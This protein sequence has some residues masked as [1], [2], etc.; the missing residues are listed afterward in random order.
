MRKLCRI[1]DLL[2]K[3]S[4]GEMCDIFSETDEISLSII[5]QEFADV[6]ISNDDGRSHYVCI[7]CMQQI[8]TGHRIWKKIRDIE[9]RPYP[10]HDA[11]SEHGKESVD[12][13][14]AI[15][16]DIKLEQIIV[17]ENGCEN[18][19]GY[20]YEFLEDE[21]MDDNVDSEILK[22]SN[23][24]E[25]DLEDATDNF[26]VETSET[27]S[28]QRTVRDTHFEMPKAEV[29]V[30]VI[31]LLDHSVVEVKGD[32][33]CGCSFVGVNRQEL[34]EHSTSAHSIEI[35]ETENYCPICF[36]KFPTESRLRRHVDECKSKRIYV[37]KNCEKY[38]NRQRQIEAHLEKC[39]NTDLS[40]KTTNNF[41]VLND[42]EYDSDIAVLLL[43]ESENESYTDTLSV[44]E[45]KSEENDSDT[46][47]DQIDSESAPS[48]NKTNSKG[49][50]NLT[51]IIDYHGV[52]PSSVAES[53]IVRRVKFLTFQ[54][55]KLKGERC[56][57]CDF[58]CATRE[59]LL[60]HVQKTH[61]QNVTQSEEFVCPICYRH[62]SNEKELSKHI[63]YVTS[64]DL[65]ICSICN[66]AFC[67]TDGL[68]HH[69][70][71]S[72]KHKQN[73]LNS[74]GN[75]QSNENMVREL[76]NDHVLKFFELELKTNRS[77]KQTRKRT[78]NRSG[79]KYRHLTMPETHLI[80]QIDEYDN[81]QVI[82]VAGERCCGCVQF[83]ETYSELLQHGRQIHLTEN[84]NVAGEYQCSICFG[85]FDC[86]RGLLLH[87]ASQ[88]SGKK[89][90]HCKICDLL[91]SKQ[92]TISKHLKTAPN[93]GGD[94]I[95]QVENNS[96]P[97]KLQQGK[98]TTK[99][100]DPNKQKLHVKLRNRK[101][102]CC[103]PKCAKEFPSETLLLEH[104]E[105]DHSGKRRE[106]ESERTSETNVCPGC[107][108]AFENTTCLVWH[109]F[110]RFTKQY[111]CRYC[112]QTF[113]RWPK[114]R[115]HENTVHLGKQTEFPCEACG[116]VFRT[117][118][119]LKA[120]SEVHSGLRKHVCTDCGA[121][122]RN[123]G[124]LKRHRR[125]VHAS[126]FPFDCKHCS[127]KFP[128]QEQLNAHTRVH[129]GAK[130]YTC[131]F[132]ERGFS[133]FTDRKRHEMS[134]HT[135]ERPH[136]CIYC[137]A[138]YVRNRELIVHMQ[139]HE[140]VL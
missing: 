76:N 89:L 80:T 115:E 11:S 24:L 18:K 3:D 37:C 32:R 35:E 50:I 52:Q 138:A 117:A 67:G 46:L 113:T 99:A 45:A 71:K 60:E 5:M 23:I 109:R 27:S 74:C 84:A 97:I 10:C 21:F 6:K 56:C 22:V 83:Y 93:H 103:L 120:H 26:S 85:R 63:N 59:E 44:S 134:T 38:F 19:D 130:P 36:Y 132:C 39:K 92:F 124:V 79:T 127:K 28:L 75:P 69:Q 20:L 70:Q 81:Y 54:Y 68:N 13:A 135:G 77:K 55:L 82:T 107:Y 119:R 53:Q 114:F 94:V 125:A 65:L 88:K 131:R 91:F 15:D 129:T 64:K 136:Q 16:S 86:I 49:K 108:K 112:D 7:D 31:D 66:E 62:F 42:G 73:L 139:K 118:P 121:S 133:H 34:L 123:K 14:F 110:T 33:C 30:Q 98:N 126:E 48:N 47:M 122:F 100:V 116:K 40:C 25:H 111:R 51:N 43:S 104:C 72:E 105:N 4:Y 1:C 78:N 102:V 128:T 57:G 58:I 137:P 41:V 106:N 95:V 140:D 87:Q 101:F 96:T 29:I 8:K 2:E 17:D 9:L 12:Q 61:A 90:F